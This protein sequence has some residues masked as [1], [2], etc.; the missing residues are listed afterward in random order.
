VLLRRVAML[1]LMVIG[2]GLMLDGSLAL[3]TRA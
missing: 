1:T 2:V 3:W